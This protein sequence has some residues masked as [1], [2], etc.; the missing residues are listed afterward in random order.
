MSGLCSKLANMSSF[1]KYIVTNCSQ[2]QTFFCGILCERGSVHSLKRALNQHIIN[3]HSVT[4][5][6][7]LMGRFQ[8][9]LGMLICI[10]KYAEE[11][12]AGVS[13]TGGLRLFIFYPF[14]NGHS[15]HLTPFC[16][17]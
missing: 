2:K 7:N 11:T 5:T 4:V 6:S 3:H 10:P 12:E 17:F 15:L 14:S 16:V 9:M 1:Q 13:H 8:G